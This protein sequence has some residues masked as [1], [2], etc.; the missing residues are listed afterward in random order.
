MLS[1]MKTFDSTARL[2]RQIAHQLLRL[3]ILASAGTLAW[4]VPSLQVPALPAEALPLPPTSFRAVS[5]S[6]P[7]IATLA[8]RLKRETPPP[9]LVAAAPAA[10]VVAAPQWELVATLVNPGQTPK[11]FVRAKGKL[12]TLEPGQTF[13]GAQVKEIAPDQIVLELQGQLFTFRI[14]RKPS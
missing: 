1:V 5:D 10:P 2:Q 7:A 11:A 14:G 4:A 12:A 3:G 8:Q 9:P 6:E 13:D